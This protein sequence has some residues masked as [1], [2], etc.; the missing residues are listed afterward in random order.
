MHPLFIADTATVAGW[1]ELTT[2]VPHGARTY[3]VELVNGDG[4]QWRSD[5]V[6]LVNTDL[7]SSLRSSE[8]RRR[9]DSSR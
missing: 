2:L 1:R 9:S 8:R 4:P 7:V 3:P 5:D 6:G